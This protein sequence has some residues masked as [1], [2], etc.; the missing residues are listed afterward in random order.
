MQF[1]SR[2][3]W[4]LQKLK[5]DNLNPQYN[6]TLKVILLLILQVHWDESPFD[7][8]YHP[9][10]DERLYSIM[11]VCME[12]V[13]H[14]NTLHYERVFVHFRNDNNILGYIFPL[15]WEVRKEKKKKRYRKTKKV[16]LLTIKFISF[17]LWQP[18]IGDS[19]HN[20]LDICKMIFTE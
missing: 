3:R 19:G 12:Y 2:L 14:T 11:Y 4:W 1:R 7:S 20:C 17:S 15:P 5:F 13:L 8:E 6:F 16:R 10:W 9:V 18:E